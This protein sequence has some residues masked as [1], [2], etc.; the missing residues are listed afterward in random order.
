MQQFISLA[1]LEYSNWYFGSYSGITFNTPTTEPISFSGNKISQFEGCATISDKTGKLLFNT[2]GEYVINKNG[3]LINLG[4]PLYGHQTSTQSAIIIPKPGSNHLY[5]I[6]TA[7]AGE[8]L[9]NTNRG[10]NYSV[11]DIN[12]NLGEGGLVEVNKPLIKPAC[13]QLTAVYHANNN[14]VWIVARGPP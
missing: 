6:F 14:D 12:A 5:Y 7:D 1:Q 11:L 13:E 8:Y 3:T 4:N 9:G 10:I 2:N